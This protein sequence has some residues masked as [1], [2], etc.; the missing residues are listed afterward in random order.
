ME[1]SE[2]ASAKKTTPGL[3]AAMIASGETRPEGPMGAAQTEDEEGQIQ[4]ELEPF[5]G[6]GGHEGSTNKPTK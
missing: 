3:V 5:G 4:Q 1:K 6:C 2:D